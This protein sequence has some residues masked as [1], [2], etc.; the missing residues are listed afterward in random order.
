MDLVQQTAAVR[1]ERAVH[2]AGR[3][4]CVGARGKAF[5]ALPRGIVAD[6]QVALDQVDLF[7][8]FV[9]ERLSREH[10]WRKSQQAGSAAAAALFVEQTRQDLLLDARWS[11]TA[12][13]NRNS[14]R[15]GGIRGGAC[16]RTLLTLLSAGPGTC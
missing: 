14:C 2:R 12:S 15:R 10:P 9:D 1:F 7:P 16:S 13:T 6:R 11:R 5:A 8:I 4:A 3:A